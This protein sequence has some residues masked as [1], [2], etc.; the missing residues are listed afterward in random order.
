MARGGPKMSDPRRNVGGM[1]NLTRR[2]RTSRP[3]KSLA[4]KTRATA[5]KFIESRMGAVSLDVA[6]V[7]WSIQ[8]VPGDEY[9]PPWAYTVGL[10]ATH[11]TP[12]FTMAGLPVEHMTIILSTIAERVVDGENIDVADEVDG[13]CPCSLT[14]RPVHASWR[15]TNM[16]PRS[17][18][19]SRR[20]TG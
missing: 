17:H 14:I 20:R 4:T 5:A 9:A 10:W 12:E 18:A 11:R 19:T 3:G 13:I 6:T 8:V 2:R 15:R 7:G 16:L 1:M